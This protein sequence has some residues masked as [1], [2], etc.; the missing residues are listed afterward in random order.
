MLDVLENVAAGHRLL[1]HSASGGISER[2]LR[3]FV[4]IRGGDAGNMSTNGNIAT[5]EIPAP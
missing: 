1:P 3:R 5:S 2:S 4:V